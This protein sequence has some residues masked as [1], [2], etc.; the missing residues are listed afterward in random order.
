MKR[1]TMITALTV[2]C[3]T[4]LFAQNYKDGFYFAQDANYAA[5][6][7]KNQVVIEVKGGRIA[8]VNWNIL[9][10]NHGMQDLKSIAKAGTVPAAVTW[11]SQAAAVEAHLISSQSTRNTNVAGGPSNARPVFDLADKAVKGRAIAKGGFAK[12]G[13]FY[14]EDTEIDDH[15]SR[16]TVLVTIVNGTIVDTL[17][18]GI[19][20][21]MHPSVNKSK[22]ITSRAN[23][24]PMNDDPVP[25]AGITRVRRDNRWDQ[26][27]DRVA[28]ELVKTQNLASIK[29]R[30]DTYTDAISGVSIKIKHFVDI[31]GRALEGAR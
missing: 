15:H 1:L 23:G 16:N 20:E 25:P 2:L 31:A 30:P 26:Q 28:A 4:I 3:G 13:W 9:S 11:A 10:L 12:D 19:L 17:W 5:N 18:N 24:Y 21:G 8:S 27:A 22:M 6:N 14:A 29:V 7:Q